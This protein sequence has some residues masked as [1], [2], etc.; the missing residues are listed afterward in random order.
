MPF[1]SLLNQLLNDIP[2]A[3]GVIILD[4]EGEA[5]AQAASISEY[6]MK[7]IGAHC[8][9]IVDRLKEMLQRVD[10]GNFEEMAFRCSSGQTVIAPL[11]DEY[12][13]VVQLGGAAVVASAV[14]RMRD[15]VAALRHDF[16][17]E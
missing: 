2:D 11:S 15:C 8:G 4:W 5:V 3:R 13:L 7:V 17:F 1:S 10:L 6:D 14:F 9:I 12:L 16:I